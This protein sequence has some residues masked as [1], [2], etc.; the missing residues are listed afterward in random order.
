M[1]AYT[2]GTTPVDVIRDAVSEQCPDGFRMTI[3]NQKEWETIAKAVNVGID[4][5]L[6]AITSSTFNHKGGEC[7]VSAE[8]MPVLLR[9][10]EEIGSACGDNLR[11]SIL[12]TLGIEE[13]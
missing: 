10:L 2:F 1:Q 9:R 8:D 11:M 7:V 13:I 5:H 6:E 3:Q 4:A 12:Y